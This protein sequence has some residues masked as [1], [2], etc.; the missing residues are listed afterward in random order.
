MI[1]KKYYTVSVEIE[2]PKVGKKFRKFKFSVEKVFH[3]G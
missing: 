2:R 1:K 3:K